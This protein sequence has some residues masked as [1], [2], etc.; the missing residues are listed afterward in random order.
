MNYANKKKMK[1]KIKIHQRYESNFKF[2][3]FSFLFF[4]SENIFRGDHKLKFHLSI[5]KIEE[6]K[7]FT[8]GFD[9]VY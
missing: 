8:T 1:I 6:E 7:I 5:I 9:F 4:L 2:I 3:I